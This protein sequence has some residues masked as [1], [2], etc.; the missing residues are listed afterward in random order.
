LK[1]IGTSL[2]AFSLTAQIISSL[3]PIPFIGFAIALL[4]FPLALKLSIKELFIINLIQ[5]FFTFII[6]I[7]MIFNV[8]SFY[9]LIMPQNLILLFFTSLLVFVPLLSIVF[10][11]FFALLM[12]FL[13]K[14]TP[15]QIKAV[16]NET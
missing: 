14:F 1:T 12:K 7:E 9:L 6:Q 10:S 3:T 11:L 15:K 4:G 8:V 13:S 16:L 2:L 5:F